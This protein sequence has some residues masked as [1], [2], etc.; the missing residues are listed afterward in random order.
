M[1]DFLYFQNKCISQRTVSKPLETA[2]TFG[3]K[4]CKNNRENLVVFRS[5]RDMKI[6]EFLAKVDYHHP[7]SF[8]GLRSNV[9]AMHMYR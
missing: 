9:T 8:I 6:V 2:W 1:L 3:N 7:F 5:P 4:M